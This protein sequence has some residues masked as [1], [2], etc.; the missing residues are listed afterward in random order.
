M[1]KEDL[2]KGQ[3]VRK[4]I[5]RPISGYWI[6]QMMVPWISAEKIIEDSEGDPDIFHNFVLGL[7]FISKDT[8]VTRESIIKCISPGHNPKTKVANINNINII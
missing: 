1:H 4:F 2:I 3:W 8:A 5:N 6:S 7:P